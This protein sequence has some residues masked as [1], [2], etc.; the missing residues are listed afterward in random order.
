MKFTKEELKETLKAKLTANGKK[1]AISDKTLTAN[2]ETLYE[3]GAN[4]ETELEDFAV[5][6]LPSIESLEGNYRKDQSDFIKDWKARE[7]KPSPTPNSKKETGEPDKIDLLLQE[8]ATLKREH[9]EEK[10]AREIESKRG[11]MLLK[12]KELGVKDEKWA[13]SYVVKINVSKDADIEK[14]AQDALTFYNQSK[15][16]FSP[17][18]T[19]GQAGGRGVDDKHMFDDIVARIKKNRE[20]YAQVQEK[21]TT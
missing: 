7:P 16:A 21:Q 17:N 4:E 2:I 8:V 5:K 19:P 15:A 3:I 20:G 12:M 18:V 11:A 14:E 10:A 13:Q 9:E 1:L 6:V